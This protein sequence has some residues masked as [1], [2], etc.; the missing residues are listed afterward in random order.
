MKRFVLV[1][2][3]V[4]IITLVGCR[5]D[6]ETI[7]EANMFSIHVEAPKAVQADEL[8]VVEGTLINNSDSS[9]ELHH[10]ADMFTYDLYDINGERVLQDVGLRVVNDIG[11]MMTL[12]PDETY[13]NDGEGHVNPKNNEFTL[14]A[15]NYE[16]VSKAIFRIKH[17][18]K[19]YDF[20]IES[21][22]LK[23]KVS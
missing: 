15:G 11:F 22:H 18:A 9:W 14:P 8:F 1:S 21:A 4:I 16:L 19:Y 7:P 6:A 20:E 17:R 3:L 23:I 5:S 12:K 13:S 10:G 2:L